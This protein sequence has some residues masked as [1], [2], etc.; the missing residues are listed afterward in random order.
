M[1]TPMP[2]P[3]IPRSQL[4]ATSQGVFGM[5]FTEEQLRA[6]MVAAYNEAMEDAASAIDPLEE[7]RGIDEKAYLIA[8]GIAKCIRELKKETP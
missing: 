7:W 3:A 6:A 8:V 2:E 5:L 4:L 1:K